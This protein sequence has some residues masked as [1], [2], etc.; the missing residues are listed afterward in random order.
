MTGTAPVSM[1]GILDAEGNEITNVVCPDIDYSMIPADGGYE[2][3]ICDNIFSDDEGWFAGCGTGRRGDGRGVVKSGA[4]GGGG[5]S[6]AH[7]SGVNN[8][9]MLALLIAIL[10]VGWLRC[11][12][13]PT[14]DQRRCRSGR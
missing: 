10:G 11:R 14:R 9:T 1:S 12:Y 2:S 5:C 7:G 13:R 6:T 4:D 3:D 8:P